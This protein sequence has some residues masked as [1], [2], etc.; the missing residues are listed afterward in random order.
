MKEIK[1]NFED[2]STEQK[3]INLKILKLA[4][5]YKF[6][7]KQNDLSIEESIK[8]INDFI[9]EDENFYSRCFLCNIEKDD[10]K[11]LEYLKNKY[12]NK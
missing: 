3:L 10:V 8:K 7:G 6:W 11:N 12:F 1:L 4:I 9:A 5:G 2:E